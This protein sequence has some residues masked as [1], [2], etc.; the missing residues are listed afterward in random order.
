VKTYHFLAGLPRS[1]NTLLSSILNQHPDIYSSPISPL[2]FYLHNMQVF[3]DTDETPRRLNDK[4]PL[5]NVL[6]NMIDNYY[7]DINKS[8]IFDRNKAWATPANLAVMQQYITPNPKIVFTT[9]PI[10]EIL[11][12]FISILP[13]NSYI[14]IEMQ[15]QGWWCKSY[16]TENDNRC[17]YLMRP[18]GLI[19]QTLM[20]INEIIKPENKNIFCLVKYEEII[21]T[22]QETMNKI[23]DF[24]ELPNHQHDFNNITKHEIDN[25]DTLGLPANLHEIRPQLKKISKDP[26]EV[27]SEYVINK[28]SNIGWG[29][30][31]D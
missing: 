19:D 2:P 1:G 26:K 15:Q 9:R 12:S 30:Y 25:D 11:T 20:G 18:F 24:L 14:D 17:D 5:N 10:I 27:L 31:K 7:Q 22:P 29:I 13:K 4:K 28:Y 23:Y 21:N 16:L 8:I 3:N 6:K